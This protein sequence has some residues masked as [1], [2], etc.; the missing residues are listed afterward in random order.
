MRDIPL[1]DNF[2]HLSD[3]IPVYARLLS[4]KSPQLS[5]SVGQLSDKNRRARATR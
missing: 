5:D 1:S 4:D 3:I 2:Y